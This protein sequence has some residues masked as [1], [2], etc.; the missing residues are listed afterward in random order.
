LAEFLV[1]AT[2]CR[3]SRADFFSLQTLNLLNDGER[4]RAGLNISLS[5]ML[6]L[7]AVWGGFAPASAAGTI[8]FVE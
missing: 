3:P 2:G 4:F 5:L 6:C 1:D 7:L 8:K